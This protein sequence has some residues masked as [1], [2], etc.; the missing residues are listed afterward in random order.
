[1]SGVSSRP[2]VALGVAVAVLLAILIGGQALAVASAP[3]GGVAS[4]GRIIGQ[5]GFAYLGGLRTFAAAVLWNRL[6]PLFDGYYHDRNVDE[7]VMFLPTMRLVQ[8]L[9]PQFEQSYYN[10]S[11]IVSR[12]GKMEEAL[13]IARE[14]IKNN[15][16]SGL[17]LANY[18]QLL[19]I[20]DKKGNMPELLKLAEQ[21]IRPETRWA[22]VD[23]RFEGYGIVRTVFRLAGN[24]QMVDAINK[25]Q[26]ALR[27]QGA[28]QGEDFPG[29]P[30]TGGN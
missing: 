20:Q 17:M 12:Q 2:G 6:D 5:T 11:F 13:D 29:L 19:L 7:I 4:T 25:A 24:Q 10:S 18:A 21:A 27:Q 1:V 8:M 22:T 3:P 15:P 26:D 16:G 14:G 30:T 28:G 23:D 9:D